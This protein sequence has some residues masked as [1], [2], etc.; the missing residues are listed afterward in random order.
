MLPR[1]GDR[2]RAARFPESLAITGCLCGLQLGVCENC[3]I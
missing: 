1:V 2:S 3:H